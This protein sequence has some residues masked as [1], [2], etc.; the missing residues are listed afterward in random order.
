ME[1]VEP[2]RP[3]GAPAWSVVQEQRKGETAPPETKGKSKERAESPAGSW[4][5]ASGDIPGTEAAEEVQAGEVR[6]DSAVVLAPE[7]TPLAWRA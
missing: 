5:L 2:S 4:Q 6:I 1:P 7:S 3:G